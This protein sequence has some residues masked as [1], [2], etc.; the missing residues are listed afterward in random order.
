MTDATERAVGDA[1]RPAENGTGG[2]ER[3]AEAAAS[4]APRPPEAAGG[5]EARP[6]GGTEGAAGGAARAVDGT[7]RRRLIADAAIATLARAGQ[8]GLTHRAVDQAAGL[9]E[10][11]CSY[12]FRTRQALL[13]ATV[14]RLVEADTADL[15]AHPAILGGSAE[16]EAVAGAAV[17]IIRYWTTETRERT[18]A[19]FELMLEAGRR[20]ELQAVLDAARVHYRALARGVLTSLGAADP[21][22]QAQ[23][24]VACL[25]GLVFRHLT[26]ADPLTASPEEQRRVLLDVL[27]GFRRDGDR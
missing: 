27:H 2:A 14:E 17:E 1:A 10:G 13:Q 22:G 16:P 6:G 21:A 24:F 7:A 5:G 4:G 8:R 18:L 23:L 26:G 9:P 20:P 3:P 12:Y 15:T 11:S 19:R 25:D